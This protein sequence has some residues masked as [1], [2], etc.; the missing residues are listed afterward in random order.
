ML[1]KLKLSTKL[2]GGF[3]TMT[4]ITLVVGLVGYRGIIGIQ[5][6]LSE[7]F[8]VRLPA[9]NY[10]I[11]SDR[12][13]YQLLVAERSMVYASPGSAKF[14]QLLEQYESNLG[15]SKARWDKY[16]ALADSAAEHEL[17]PRF[18][19]ARDEWEQISRH[20]VDMRIANSPEGEAEAPGLSLGLASDKFDE[21]REYL[22]ELTEMNLARADQASSTTSETYKIPIIILFSFIGVGTFVSVVLALVINRA[23]SKPLMCAVAGL[24]DVADQVST[25]ADELSSSS[26][27][28]ASGSSAQAESIMETSSSL[29]EMTSM[30]TQT[31]AYSKEANDLMTDVDRVVDNANASMTNLTHSIDDIS[32][33]SKETAKIVKTI[34][35][36]AFRTNLL[37]LNAAVEAARAGEA[38]V[39]FAVVAEEVRNLARRSADAARTTAELIDATV[40]KV[41]G[42]SVLVAGTSES[43]T[44]VAESATR[45]SQLVGEM[46]TASSEQAQGIEQ[47]NRA[48]SEMD[49]VV[50]QNAASA[51]EN[52]G[53]SEGMNAQAVR[54]KGMVADLA[55]LV[56]GSHGDHDHQT[57]K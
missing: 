14:A 28:V 12:D 42:G 27:S 18:E 5:T 17:I 2:I 50:R 21:M 37:A 30:T 3:L 8:D 32:N 34:D 49:K 36:I 11:E 33:A 4:M 56:V 41:K 43:F 48:V 38:G 7:V 20:V 24:R 16:K 51:E 52:A 47:I 35:E 25:T 45:V 46:S 31:A 10:L 9:I 55:A 29:E 15:Q 40:Q 1:K 53:A 44:R 6:S 57:R 13:L 22:D 54:M 26:H 23:I 19:N 39:G